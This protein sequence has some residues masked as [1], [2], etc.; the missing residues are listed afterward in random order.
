MYFQKRSN[1][2]RPRGWTR[3]MN[4]CLQDKSL[5]QMH[6]KNEQDKSSRKMNRTKAQENSQAK[7]TRKRHKTE[8]Q[9][10]CT[11]ML[12]E[13]GFMSKNADN[14]PRSHSTQVTSLE[15]QD[16]QRTTIFQGHDKSKAPKKR[17]ASRAWFYVSKRR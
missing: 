11:R 13:H 2:Q 15:D 6:K 8:A 16:S 12:A 4:E 5:S 7:C 3:A 9:A 1:K 14:R 17:N 10:K